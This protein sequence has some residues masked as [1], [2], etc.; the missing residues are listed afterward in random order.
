MQL[1]DD[2]ITPDAAEVWQSDCPAV[3]LAVRDTLSAAATWMA[4]RHKSRE[5]CAN[6]EL[7]LAEVCNNIV[8]HAYLGTGC[9]HI[10]I[11]MRDATCG[12]TCLVEDRGIPM[13]DG[14]T[15]PRLMAGLPDERHQL[16]VCGFGW[17][18]IHDLAR[19]IRYRREDG[20]N[21]LKFT[22]PPPEQA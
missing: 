11:L 1:R 15:E 5:L 18:L 22:V 17:H 16:P 12:L 21:L 4:G 14:L 3:P 9:G 13:P 7:V 8:A 2:M 6:A 10:R 19:D 20:V